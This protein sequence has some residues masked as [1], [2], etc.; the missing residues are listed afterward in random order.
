M[1]FIMENGCTGL[2]ALQSW[3]QGDLFPRRDR[4]KLEECNGQSMGVY[5][6]Q[7]DR[8]WVKFAR[9]AAAR[10]AGM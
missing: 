3:E 1:R 9:L 7:H 6:Q 2:L 5:T 4:A 10:G 8:T